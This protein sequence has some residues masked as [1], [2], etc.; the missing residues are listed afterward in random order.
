MFSTGTGLTFVRFIRGYRDDLSDDSIL[1]SVWARLMFWNKWRWASLFPRTLPHAIRLGSPVTLLSCTSQCEFPG[2]GTLE[3]QVVRENISVLLLV[4]KLI[5]RQPFCPSVSLSLHLCSSRRHSSLRK[6]VTP[7]GRHYSND[8]R[9]QWRWL[10]T[11][12]LWRK[13]L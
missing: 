12:R 4:K 9:T 6:R 8:A 3:L 2:R 13:C 10:L 1:S 11:R 5:G 7:T